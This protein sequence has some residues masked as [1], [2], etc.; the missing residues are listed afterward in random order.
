MKAEG[1]PGI[2]LDYCNRAIIDKYAR[3][4]AEA[5]ENPG[6]WTNN[7]I[8]SPCINYP[9]RLDD[10]LVREYAEYMQTCKCY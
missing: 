9:P 4:W 10:D 5:M 2:Q 3:D 7:D 1:Y 8:R 6:Y